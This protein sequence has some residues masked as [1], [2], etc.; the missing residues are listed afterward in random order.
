M[1]ED[2]KAVE[3]VAAE[4]GFFYKP[5]VVSGQNVSDQM[6]LNTE[7]VEDE[8]ALGIMW[9]IKDDLFYIKV[10]ASGKKIASINIS[11]IIQ[12]PELKLTLRICLSLHAKAFDPLGLILPLKMRGNLLFRNTL[13]FLSSLS[14]EL[15]ENDKV[16]KKLPWD[17]E[18]GGNLKEKWLDY[19][20]MLESVQDV[21]FPR[22]IKPANVKPNTKPSLVTFLDGNEGA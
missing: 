17:F 6:V 2:I 13:Q 21:K 9:S 10:G 19:F 7:E 1:E 4:G 5:W 11:Q 14:K 18:V 20:Q 8:R 3:K 22:S 16:S 15:K 12:N